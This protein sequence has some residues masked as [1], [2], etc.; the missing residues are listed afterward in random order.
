VKLPTGRD[1]LTTIAAGAYHSLAAVFSP[2][3]Q[4]PVEV[5]QDLLLIYNTNSADSAF[6]KDY[7]LAHRPM[8]SEANVLGLGYTNPVSPG[9]YET[10]SPPELTNQLFTP[11]L[12][13]L[14]ANPTKRPQYV[15]LFMDL[16]ARV[17]SSSAAPAYNEPYDAWN[18]PGTPYSS[19]SMQLRSLAAWRNWSSI[20][21]TP[22]RRGSIRAACFVIAA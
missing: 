14:E 6:V 19:V 10:I 5:S 2:L 22:G 3:V 11:L 17:S 9:H 12:S 8:V 15:I 21:T 1:D 13:W 4:Y 16:P 7:Y 20:G 18:Y